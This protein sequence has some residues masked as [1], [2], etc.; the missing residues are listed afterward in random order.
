MHNIKFA[1][2]ATASNEKLRWTQQY[3]VYTLQ[4]PP[5]Q[6]DVSHQNTNFYEHDN[7]QNKFL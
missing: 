1:I 5:T 2:A 7:K 6:T 4:F 3:W